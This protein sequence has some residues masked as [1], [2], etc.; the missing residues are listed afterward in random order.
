M[1]KRRTER[2]P[3]GVP[4][5]PMPSRWDSPT[6]REVER[7]KQR[8]SKARAELQARRMRDTVDAIRARDLAQIEAQKQAKRELDEHI[9]RL[10]DE[11]DEARARLQ[12]NPW[13]NPWDPGYQSPTEL[14]LRQAIEAGKPNSPLD[15]DATTQRMESRL[16][17]VRPQ[18]PVVGAAVQ[19]SAKSTPTVNGRP[20]FL[21]SL[22]RM[23]PAQVA[24]LSPGAAEVRRRWLARG[25]AVRRTTRANWTLR[26]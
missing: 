6:M 5:D 13:L 21:E 15:A 3:G 16:R 25:N 22:A 18:E 19:M 10:A 24:A 8:R 26:P 9:R 12:P 17:A 14:A 23:S 4:L 11:L 2:G 1:T 7:E 20:S